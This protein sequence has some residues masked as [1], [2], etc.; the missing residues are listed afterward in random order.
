[1]MGMKLLITGG[2]GFIGSN[3]VR[4]WRKNHPQDQITVLDKLTYAGNL[5]SLES[6]IHEIEFIEGDIADIKT[7]HRAMAGTDIVV[8]FAAETHVDR[9]IND[10]YIFTKTNNLGTHTLLEVARQLGVKRFHHV[11]TDEVF[12]Q[13]PLDESWQFTEQTP[14]QPSSPYSA[15]KAGSDHMVRAYYHTYGLPITISNCSNNF[16][17][18]HHPEKFIP[19]SITRLMRGQNIRLYI[20]GNQ[21]RDWLHVEDHCRA[22]ETILKNG[23]L[24]ETYN[25]GG[26]AKGISNLEVAKKILAILGLP[27]NRI[28]LVTDR[29]GHD[30]KYDIDW[31]KLNRELGWAPLHSF[32]E[33]LTETVL[34]YQNH[35][36]WWQPLVDE[37]EAFYES[38]GEKV[39]FPATLNQNLETIAPQQPLTVMPQQSLVPVN[40]P[41]KPFDYII[42]TGLPGVMIIE[43]PTYHDDRGFFRETFRK[44]DLE[45]RLGIEL[46][47]VQA[48][49][50]RS[51]KGTLRGI[52]IAPWHKLITVANG[53]VQAVLVDTRKDSPTYGQHVSLILSDKHPRSIFVPAGIG[54]SF[55]VLSD[56]ADYTYITTEYW[57]PNRE[58]NL[59]YNDPDLGISWLN[60][61]P[62]V[63][64]K[65]RT[66]PTLKEL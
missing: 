36:D 12:G 7:V 60:S 15:S 33:W 43:R 52:H 6:V 5:N 13:I 30:V 9:S 57:T 38:R 34:W 49:H 48:N 28:E 35:Q 40:T 46:N 14:Y 22:I 42:E 37:T 21:I 31:T 3:F 58:R 8:H 59:L 2:A 27:E 47:F 18:Y 55:L 29:P 64:D 41:N 26:M 45:Q 50:S 1:M 39:L 61:E 63:S 16:G 20:P 65:D 11:S 62:T 56:Q 17:P 53:E 19:R 10:P 25:I 54:N 23:K 32:D 44:Q 4:F 51:S 66:N 24:G